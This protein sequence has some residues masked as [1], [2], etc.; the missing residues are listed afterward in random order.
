[1]EFK[2]NLLTN[3]RKV[4]KIILAQ[5]RACSSSEIKLESN[6]IC[7]LITQMPMFCDGNNIMLYLAMSDEV[8]IDQLI[9]YCF[10]NGKKVAVPD[11]VDDYGIMKPV[12]LNNW[13]ELSIGAFGI[14]SVNLNEKTYMDTENIDVVI[15]PAVAYNNYGARLGMGRGFYDRFLSKTAAVK[16][17]V[18]LSCQMISE[19]PSEKHDVVVDY[20]VTT[21]GIVNCKTGKMC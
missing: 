4:R 17:G 13:Q 8:N 6:G 21:E 3:K 15:V 2:N 10:I 12:I 5:R 20:V 18:A 19:I 9:D 11:I 1:M 16:I 14:R 7:R